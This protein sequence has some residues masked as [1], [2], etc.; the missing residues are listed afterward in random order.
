MQRADAAIA[1]A[2]SSGTRPR[3]TGRTRDTNAMNRNILRSTWITFIALLLATDAFALSFDDV[4]ID[5]TVGSGANE[6]MIVVDWETGATP[7][8]AWRFRWDGLLSY[9]DALDAL[10]ANVTGFSWSQTSFV[11]FVNYDDGSEQNFSDYPG[12]LSFWESADGE[13]WIDTQLG[14][15]QQL[16]VDGGWMGVNANLPEIWPGDAPSLPVP[17]PS[18]GV[19]VA[20]SLVGLSAGQRRRS[21]IRRRC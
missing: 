7:S 2:N 16:L 9:A 5:G 4:L 8:H 17:E 11:Q 19:L 15:Y 1:R 10:T 13:T 20:L 3:E 14:V 18:T 6:T 12:W 21:G